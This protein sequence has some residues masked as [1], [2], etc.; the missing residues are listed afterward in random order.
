MLC[1]GSVARHVL[2]GG[3]ALNA[4]RRVRLPM[5]TTRPRSAKARRRPLPQRRA[6]RPGAL[7]PRMAAASCWSRRA[8]SSR[9]TRSWSVPKVSGTVT[10]LTIEE[11]KRVKKGD[12][13]PKS[14]TSTT[15]PTTSIALGE[16]EL[17]RQK[18]LELEQGNRPEEIA[19]VEGPT[20]GGRGQSD[21][22]RGRLEAYAT[23]PEA[24]TSATAAD[25]DSAR[26]KYRA[27][28][29]QDRTVPFCLQPDAGRLRGKKRIDA[30]VPTSRP[31]SRT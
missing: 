24:T 22:A 19:Q 23:T 3:L 28:M 11:G 21:H 2:R 6:P 7:L 12:I 4:V 13:S 26:S 31:L 30:G 14:K 1:G 15:A 9:P 18:L 29:R 27:M 25:Y 5:Q 20:G 10:R 8:I 16:P 17:A